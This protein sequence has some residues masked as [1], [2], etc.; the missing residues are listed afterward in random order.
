MDIAAM[1][2]EDVALVAALEKRC[3]KNPWGFA[4]FAGELACEQ[5]YSFVLKNRAQE[6]VAYSCFRLIFSDLHVLKLAVNENWRRR[7]IARNFF[8]QCVKRLPEAVNSAFLEVRPSNPAAIGLYK[9]LGFHIWGRRPEYYTD[10]GEDA[11]IM[12]KIFK[13][14]SYEYEDSH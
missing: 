11:L 9:K 3:F 6:L 8:S 4:A 10:T 5:S 13:G 1:A 14:G 12:G 7:G 2:A